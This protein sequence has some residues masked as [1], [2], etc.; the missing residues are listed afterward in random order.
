MV[1]EERFPINRIVEK[2]DERNLTTENTESTEAPPRRAVRCR[3]ANSFTLLAFSFQR[4]AWELEKSQAAKFNTKIKYSKSSG[5][6]L[7]DKRAQRKQ[8]T[9]HEPQIAQITKAIICASEQTV[10]YSV[11]GSLSLQFFLCVLCALCG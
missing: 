10:I 8:K 6:D 9:Y 3:A 2:S 11:Q 1:F 5:Y 4:V 7:F